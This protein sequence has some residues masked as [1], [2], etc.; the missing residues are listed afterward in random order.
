M[1]SGFAPGR[2]ADTWIVGYSTDGRS[3]TGNVK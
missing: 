3:L 1:M 2:L